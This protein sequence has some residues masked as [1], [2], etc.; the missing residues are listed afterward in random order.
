LENKIDF[1]SKT[2]TSFFCEIVNFLFKKHRSLKQTIYLNELLGHDGKFDIRFEGTASGFEPGEPIRPRVT[3]LRCCT[4]TGAIRNR[5]DLG[6]GISTG[7]SASKG[8][9]IFLFFLN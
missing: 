2:N 8:N 1:S 3:H 4:G 9:F 7:D 6:P 5:V